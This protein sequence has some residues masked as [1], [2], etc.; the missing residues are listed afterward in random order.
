M[1]SWKLLKEE[2]STL[3]AAS[4]KLEKQDLPEFNFFPKVPSKD[5]CV[6]QCYN[7]EPKIIKLI[8]FYA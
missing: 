4:L 5:Y 7:S 8:Q 1:A 2:C 6:S 3:L